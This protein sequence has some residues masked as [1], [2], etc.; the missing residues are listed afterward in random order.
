MNGG[1]V[2]LLVIVGVWLLWFVR[3]RHVKGWKRPLFRKTTYNPHA[4]AGR[5]IAKGNT[6]YHNHG[7]GASG[8]MGGGGGF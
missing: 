8:G 2:L 4:T 1:I 7:G 3:D 5:D 6:A